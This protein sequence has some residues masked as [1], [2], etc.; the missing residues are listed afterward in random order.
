MGLFLNSDGVRD[1]IIPGEPTLDVAVADN[2]QRFDGVNGP[3]DNYDAHPP[4]MGLNYESGGSPRP[5]QANS[6]LYE[7]TYT[8]GPN[9]GL[10]NTLGG[11]PLPVSNCIYKAPGDYTKGKWSLV[12]QFRLGKN[13]LGGQN[14]GGAAQTV[15]LSEITNNP[16][17]PGELSSIIAGWG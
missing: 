15:A 11:Q 16:P 6:P 13:N 1:F 2:F 8:H 9:Y 12:N 5:G 14:N 7:I 4:V 10:V 3:G 17:V